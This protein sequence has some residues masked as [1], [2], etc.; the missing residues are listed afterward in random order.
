MVWLPMLTNPL[1]NLVNTIVHT[2]RSEFPLN[3]AISGKPGV[4]TGVQMVFVAYKVYLKSTDY[5]I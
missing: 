1:T 4:Q 2:S 5:V 3:G